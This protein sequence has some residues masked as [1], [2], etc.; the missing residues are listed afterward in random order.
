M[1]RQGQRQGPFEHDEWLQYSFD[2]FEYFHDLHQGKPHVCDRTKYP[3]SHK[4]HP[5][6]ITALL[7]P[8]WADVFVRDTNDFKAALLA[9]FTQIQMLLIHQLP[10][11]VHKMLVYDDLFL[12]NF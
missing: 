1:N 5:N 4:W 8:S 6:E 2:S 7:G 3:A 10:S 11:E 12:G 9:E